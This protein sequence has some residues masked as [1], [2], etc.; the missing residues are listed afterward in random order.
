MH[1]AHCGI[2]QT[3]E[4]DTA[5]KQTTQIVNEGPGNPQN[6][7]ASTLQN[8]HKHRHRHRNEH[9]RTSANYKQ[10]NPDTPRPRRIQAVRA[11]SHRLAHPLTPA[12]SARS[13][14]TSTHTSTSTSSTPTTTS[15]SSSS[16]THTTSSSSSSSSSSSAPATTTSAAPTATP[17]NVNAGPAAGLANVLG[18]YAVQAGQPQNLNNAN[19]ALIGIS[20]LINAGVFA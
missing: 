10:L 19:Q 3:T 11:D 12:A 16:T 1:D 15:H 14:S 17:P 4:T 6:S 2:G 13:T 20:G 5:R 9:A 7:A 8:Q 18:A